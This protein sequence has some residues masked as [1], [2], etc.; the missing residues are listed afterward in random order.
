MQATAL[1]FAAG[2]LAGAMNA[3]AGG[4]TFAAFPALLAVGL[5]PT[6]ANATSN[7]ALLPGAA[8]S[9]WTY[10]HQLT[11]FGPLSL[12]AMFAVTVAGGALGA[13][14]LH[15]TGDETFRILVPWLLLAASLALTFGGWL[16]RRLEASDLTLGPRGAMV[17]QFVLGIYGGYFGGAVGLLMMAGWVLICDL[18][19]KALAPARTLFLAAANAAACVLFTALGLIRWSAALPTA[20]GAVIGG[21]LGARLG[22]R[23]PGPLVRAVVLAI[24]YV[25]TAIFFWRTYRT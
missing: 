8:A 6:V 16:R 9:A 3:L 13:L 11:A 20:V 2:L 24:T 18:D 21:Y 5:P 22:M 1:L 23:L 4:G 12:K 17:L 7:T 15:L 19:P 14:L 25:T 10:R